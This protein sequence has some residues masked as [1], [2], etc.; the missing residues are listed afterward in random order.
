MRDKWS[1]NHKIPYLQIGFFCFC[2]M[3]VITTESS[4]FAVDQPRSK[5]LYK[6]GDTPWQSNDLA[7]LGAMDRVVIACQTQLKETGTVQLLSKLSGPALDRN[8]RV[9][10]SGSPDSSLQLSLQPLTA[11]AGLSMAGVYKCQVRSTADG[12]IVLV[13]LLRVKVYGKRR[14]RGRE[15]LIAYKGNWFESAFCWRLKCSF[16]DAT[17]SCY[18]CFSIVMMSLH[19]TA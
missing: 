11:A 15:L 13:E 8:V 9:V 5:L 3:S 4:L 12:S 6:I 18:A 1:R 14:G 16:V 10:Q 2:P 17:H 7:Y 19:I